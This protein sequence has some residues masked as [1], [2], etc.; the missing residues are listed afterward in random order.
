[1]LSARTQSD[2]MDKG[3]AMMSFYDNIDFPDHY[4][5][6]IDVTK[7]PY[8][9]DSSGK[10]DCTEKLCRLLDDLTSG[11]VSEMQRIY[12]A[13]RDTPDKGTIRG[14]FSRFTPV[15]T[16]KR[17][18]GRQ[19]LSVFIPPPRPGRILRKACPR[20]ASP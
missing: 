17:S 10:E 14:I 6:I 3:E 11:T 15:E 12:A 13:L 1:M 2:N 5:G 7:A 16:H 20:P 19:D 8:L 18:A 9:L 4:K